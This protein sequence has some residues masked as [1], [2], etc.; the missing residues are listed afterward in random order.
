MTWDKRPTKRDSGTMGDLFDVR[1]KRSGTD[2]NQ[3]RTSVG[4]RS[5]ALTLGGTGDG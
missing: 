2:A 5:R 4:E 3:W 1:V